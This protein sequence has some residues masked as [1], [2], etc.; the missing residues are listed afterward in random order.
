MVCILILINLDS[1]SEHLKQFLVK[2]LISLSVFI[3]LQ[4]YLNYV[5][6][7]YVKCLLEKKIVFLGK[8][9]E[10]FNSYGNPNYFYEDNDFTRVDEQDINFCCFFKCRAKRWYFNTLMS[11]VQFSILNDILSKILY[12]IFYFQYFQQ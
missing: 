1:E 2:S 4:A 10:E 6:Y 3:L 5:C 9:E 7:N 8:D 12:A 11:N